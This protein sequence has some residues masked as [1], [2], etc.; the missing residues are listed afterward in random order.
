MKLLEYAMKIVER[1][2]ERQIRTLINLK[3]MQFGYIPKKETV[4]SMFS[5][6]RMQEEYQKKDK[7]LYICFVDMEKVFDR[8][9]KKRCSG[10]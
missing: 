6:K 1:V 4:D 9:P 2:L 3:K 5:V 7:K 10:P 8:V